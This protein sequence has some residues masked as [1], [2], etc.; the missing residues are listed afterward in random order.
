MSLTLNN[1]EENVIRDPGDQS[2]I[3]ATFFYIFTIHVHILH[4]ANN[5]IFMFKDQSN[6]HAQKIRYLII[7]IGKSAENE[8]RLGNLTLPSTAGGNF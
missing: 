3:S 8:I 6:K 5:E 1:D 7:I 2:T 4:I